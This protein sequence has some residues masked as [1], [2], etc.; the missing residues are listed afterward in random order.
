MNPN[1]SRALRLLAG[2]VLGAAVA[3]AL[4]A[5]GLG[6]VRG[7]A[8]AVAAAVTALIVLAFFA[9]GQGLQAAVADA[10]PRIALV[11][12]LASYLVRVGVLGVVVLGV[13]GVPERLQGADPVAVV[14]STVMVTIGWVSGEVAAYHK[15]RIP[16]FDSAEGGPSRPGAR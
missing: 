7:A 10:S 14:V 11:V 4:A 9:V 2:G 6:L 3:A 12:A 16:V 5:L 1:R 13:I 15:L 8:S